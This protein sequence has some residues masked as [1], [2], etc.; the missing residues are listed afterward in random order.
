M[1]KKVVVILSLIII[2]ALWRG[3]STL[4]DAA[5]Q[6]MPGS[7]TKQI[8]YS[9]FQHSSHAGLVGG[10]LKKTQSQELK[11]DY[12]HLN[13]TQDQPV[14]T[15]Y[16]NEKPGSKITHSSCI[17]CHSMAGR[18]EYP[19]MCLICHS[20][21]PLDE[22]KK[23]VRVFPNPKSGPNSQF[24]DYFS[25]S[26]H[27]GYYKSSKT[28][29]ELY[30][31]KTKFKQK[32]NFECA[33]CH[34]VNQ[35]PV[36]VG[37]VQFAKGVKERAPGH[38]ECFVCHFNEKEVDKTS[39]TFATS[40]VG[41][42]VEV[43]KPKGMGSELAVLWFD[44]M[45]VNT[46]FNPA[47]PPQK[48]G[49]K[50]TPPPPFNHQAHLG[51]YD[52]NPKG[53]F[54]KDEFGK[55]LKNVFKQG[56]DS[57]LICHETGKSALTRS[58]FYTENKKTLN[59]QPAASSCVPCHD[60]DMQKKIG[61]AVTL[62]SATCN[63][64]H[65]LQTIKARKGVELPPPSHFRDPIPVALD[66]LA[67]APPSPAA[68]TPPTPTPAPTPAP[69][70]TPKPPETTNPAPKPTEVPVST[71]K[72]TTAPAPTPTPPV[73]TVVTPVVTPA[74]APTPAPPTPSPAPTPSPSTAA[75]AP[76]PAKPGGPVKPTPTGVIKLG[77]PKFSDQWGQ[78][79]KWGVVEN[80]NHG[81]HT[82]PKYS[83]KCEDCHHTNK[84]SKVEEVLTCLSCHKG[85]DHP[86]TANKGGGVNVEDAYH[87]VPDS[88]KV[89]KAGCIECH[90]RYRD[91]DPNSKAP[92]K[93]PCSGCHTE[94]AARLDPRLMRPRRD[95]WVTAN[96]AAL[97]RWMRSSR[98]NSVA[99]L[100]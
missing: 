88:A 54:G 52:D 23:N 80:F 24:Y 61:G 32:D 81:D 50:P 30:K 82:K 37:S 92:V 25:H 26:D 69:T 44:R 89:P 3:V 57:C 73:T 95:D 99:S 79:A 87:G 27:A 75:P 38:K 5:A 11:C 77:D 74:P 98:A 22:M 17:D 1:V 68:P 85:P 43:K 100:R 63:K 94:K 93:S 12:C 40:C 51:D 76:T 29:K 71:P 42:H 14:V 36:T 15:G 91:K 4:P 33:S 47:K 62:E 90:K 65:S 35:Q 41:C 53:K 96:I 70:P 18:P 55:P 83:D 21:K 72:P 86:D 60:S 49:P 13:P 8:D 6:K 31:D 2:C 46:E 66:T 19:D 59:K 97:A 45:I 48:P 84:D 67:K 39:K 10:V 16:P 20:T 64:C 56:T 7:G 9:K 28:F 78:H 34:E 58:D